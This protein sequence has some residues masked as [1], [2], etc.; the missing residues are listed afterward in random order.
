MAQAVLNLIED[1]QVRPEDILIMAAKVSTLPQVER[2]LQQLSKHAVQTRIV[3]GRN[4]STQDEP[5]L[6][7][8]NLTLTTIHA[9]KGYDAPIAILMDV[10]D[11]PPSVTGRAMFYAGAT[12]AK[13]YLLVTGVKTPDSLLSEAQI[14]DRRLFSD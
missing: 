10:D 5:L 4:H 1:E 6:M 13:R 14:M 11:L 8:G 7:A 2:I 3:G 9:A 12:R